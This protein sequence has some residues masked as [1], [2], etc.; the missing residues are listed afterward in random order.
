VNSYRAHH[1][2]GTK[3]LMFCK[4]FCENNYLALINI[5]LHKPV[6]YLREFYSH[7]VMSSYYKVTVGKIS[8]KNVSGFFFLY[9]KQGTGKTTFIQWVLYG[10]HQGHTIVFLKADDFL[11]SEVS[12]FLTAGLFE[13]PNRIF[14]FDAGVE[15]G[16]NINAI[17][18]TLFNWVKQYKG[19]KVF[20]Y[21]VI[22]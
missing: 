6:I 20:L 14:V 1:I 9:G 21:I 7:D 10:L 11:E 12:V 13:N 16:E 2:N 4:V 5:W 8:K 18:Q 17:A 22:K 19:L 3:E 15:T